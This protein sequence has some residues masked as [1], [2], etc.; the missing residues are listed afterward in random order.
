MKHVCRFRC[1]TQKGAL[2]FL[3]GT[4]VS[5]CPLMTQ[6]GYGTSHMTERHRAG[7]LDCPGGLWFHFFNNHFHFFTAVRAFKTAHLSL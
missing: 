1:F 3:K 4:V 2:I 6:S 5:P 7:R